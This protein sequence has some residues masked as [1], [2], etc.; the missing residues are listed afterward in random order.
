MSVQLRL[1][2]LSRLLFFNLVREAMIGKLIG[3]D[4]IMFV[5]S[6]Y[7]WLN[8]D[9]SDDQRRQIRHELGL[10]VG[11]E[12][13][14]CGFVGAPAETRAPV[15]DRTWDLALTLVFQ[16]KDGHD[17]YATHPAHEAFVTRYSSSWQKV[18]IYDSE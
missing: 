3:K 2:L 16:N 15:I 11:I 17:A 12:T 4:D 8:R 18:L 5:H 7:F 13:V 9:L 10:L 6:V 1:S 14:E